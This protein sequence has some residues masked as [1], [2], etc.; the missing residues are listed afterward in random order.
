MLPS[1]PQDVNGLYDFLLDTRNPSP[2][3]HASDVARLTA[4]RPFPHAALQR[5]QVYFNAQVRMMMMMMMM[6]MTNG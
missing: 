3:G 1:L 4:P 2:P 5:L 6:M